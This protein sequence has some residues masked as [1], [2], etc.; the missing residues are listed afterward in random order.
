MKELRQKIKQEVI[1]LHDIFVEWFTGSSNKIG[2]E[3]KLKS[4]FFKETI[5]ITTQGH[6]VN[7]EG[8]MNIFQNGYGV[9]SI[10]KIAISDV[11]VLQKI[12]DYVLVNYV[13][14]QTN[15]LNPELT[16]NYNTRK[17]TALISN[18]HPFK[19]LHIHETMLS[20]PNEII[21]SLKS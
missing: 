5:F 17:S 9:N 21:E 18:K 3:S 16:G 19:W 15:D 8:L 14:W 11:E 12:G 10:F 1:D 2:L 13:E 6:S 4:R 7:Y 20:K